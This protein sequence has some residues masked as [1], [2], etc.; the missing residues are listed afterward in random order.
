MR[1]P[2]TVFRRAIEGE[3]LVAAEIKR[4][5]G[6]PAAR[7][8]GGRGVDLAR[9]H[10]LATLQAARSRPLLTESFPNCPEAFPALAPALTCPVVQLDS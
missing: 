6:G 10:A 2:R 8:A 1:N 5:D 9:A 3:N 7:T 4:P